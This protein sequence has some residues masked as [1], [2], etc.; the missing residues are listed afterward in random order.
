MFNVSGMGIF[1]LGGL[2]FLF[3]MLVSF[4]EAQEYLT[5]FSGNPVVKSGIANRIG[6]KAL[7][8]GQ[9]TV[10][11]GLPF[12][13]DFSEDDIFP[14]ATRWIDRYAF[15]NNDY[16]VFPINLGAVTMD[17]INDSGTMYA[18]AV[19]GPE[20]FIADHL[21]S[22]FI[23]LDSIFAPA[24]RKL[25]MADSVYLSFYYQPQ[26]RAYRGPSASDTLILQFLNRP[27]Y[28][29]L[30][31]GDTVVTH[32]PDKWDMVWFANGMQLDTFYLQNNKYFMQVMVPI[33]DTATYFKK[34]FRFRFLNYV[35]LA[36]SAEPSWQSNCDQWNIDNVY[37]NIGRNRYD[38]V[39]PELRFIERTPSLLE[40][41]E[42]MPYPQYC[43]DPT[44]EIR[45][46]LDI[47]ISNRD[48]NSHLST[49]GY[50]LTGE[51]IG[52]NKSYDGGSYNIQ[53]Y[54]TDGYVTWQPFAHPPMQYLFPISSADS[55]LFRMTHVVKDNTPG[56]P[57]G[58]TITG[59][60][61]FYNYFAYDDG[62]PEAGY[63]LTP[64]GSKLAYK[65]KLNKSPDTLRA[66]RFF[67]NHTLGKNNQ[68]W[69]YLCVWND[70]AG[71]PGDTIWSNLVMPRFT[72]SLN[73]FVTY[74]I[75]NGLRITG[76]FFV[77]WIQP[78]DD[79]LNVGFDRY[80]N[81]QDQIYYNSTGQWTTSS[82]T[83]SLMIRPVVG[84]PIPLAIGEQHAGNIPLTIYPNPCSS[85]T[86]NLR[87]PEQSQQSLQGSTLTVFNL[88]G[89]SLIR[90]PYST[91]VDVSTLSNGL[92]LLEMKDRDGM[93]M[94]V[95]RFII[96]R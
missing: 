37:L 13:D 71:N 54:Y 41:Y 63:G 39:Y 53:P 36:S 51:T 68:Q 93:R 2:V 31:P 74:H 47:L 69:F 50:T 44:N 70:N 25:T 11:V 35:S 65:F 3:S 5:G 4:G 87:I 24:A 95:T 22:R 27:G 12:F 7:M 16:P 60:Q 96:A 28:D 43:D 75:P 18:N 79:N 42:S 26:G 14:D 34:K 1:R 88:F 57:F 62:T 77:G 40:R 78:T 30:V 91:A 46:T 6:M 32:V 29:T 56:S 84:K 83:G 20:N 64:A 52:F 49:Y 89:Q 66:I 19:P 80:N 90:Q 38:T 94:G 8:A 10:P 72:D 85:A 61:R 21:T 58:D 67:F 59:F 86:L 17:A 55:A 81:S 76:T 33:T 45:D 73:K 9:D 92:Y 15:I 23:R 48:V 82:Y